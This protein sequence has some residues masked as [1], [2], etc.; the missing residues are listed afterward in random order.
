MDLALTEHQQ[1]LQQN[2]RSFMQRR[3][4]RGTIVA[5]HRSGSGCQPETWNTI[6]ALGWLGLLIPADYGGGASLTDAA[7]LYEEFGRGPLP[8]PFFSSGVLSA[9]TVLEG[10]TEEQ[11]RRILPEIASGRQVFTVA[12]T[13]PA[14]SWGP[15]GVVLAPERRGDR[16][17]VDGTK[18]FVSD[19]VAATHLIVALRTGSG[20]EA[21][22]L[23]VVDKQT[24]G[25]SARVLPGFLSW[26]AEVNFDDVEVPASALLGGRQDNGWAALTRAME[27]TLPVLCAYQVGS[28]QAVFERSVEYSQTRIQFG[29]PIGRFQR[30]QDHILRLVNHLDA[31]RWTTYE[32]LWKLDS[33]RPA[34][35]S[36]HL[37]KAVTA[38]AHLEA[39]N[40][41]HEVHAGIGSAHEYGLTPHTQLSRT[42]FTYLGEPRW[43]KRRM[44]DTLAW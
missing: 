6:A 4:P 34:T 11:R 31:A 28:C 44:A 17:L 22:S 14:R 10:G 39:C 3:L 8:S 9:L 24:K 27:R 1:M 2:V 42:L 43:H 35:A 5:L 25:V 20:R 12:I 33:G 30:V 37:A 26:Q 18:L 19:A 40:A 32:A 13:E 29:V 7:V 23:L 41:A 16:Y 38:E 36:V 21:I 15:Q